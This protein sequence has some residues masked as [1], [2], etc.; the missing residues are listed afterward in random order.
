MKRISINE[1]YDWKFE[2]QDETQE[3]ERDPQSHQNTVQG[4][5]A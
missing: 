1:N 3:G 2:T 5:K 4:E